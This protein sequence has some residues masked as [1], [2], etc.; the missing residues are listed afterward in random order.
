EHVSGAG[1]PEKQFAAVPGSGEE[2][3]LSSADQIDGAGRVT[4]AKDDRPAGMRYLPR[5]AVELTEQVMTEIQEG[6]ARLRLRF[7]LSFVA[8]RN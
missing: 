7:G 2:F 6:C 8:S 5:H 1:D 3:Y 4:L